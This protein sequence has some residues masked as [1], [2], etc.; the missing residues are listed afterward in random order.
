[1]NYHAIQFDGTQAQYTA[2]FC[3]LP[4]TLYSKRELMQDAETERQLIAGTHILS[5]YFQ[6]YPFLA[7]D[8][9]AQAA[10][11]CILTLYPDRTGAYIG[12]F[13]SIPD[14]DA[15][16]CVLCAA[17]QLAAEHGYRTAV[18][19]V[20]CAFWIRYRLKTDHFGEPYSGEPYNKAYYESFF[21]KA[22]YTV[23]G[24]YL[25]NRFRRIPD[26]HRSQ[27][28]EKRLAA[29]RR[30]GY[31][32]VSPDA[33]S[34]PRAL[35]EIYGMLIELYS[36]FQTFVRITEEEFVSLYTPLRHVADYSMVKIAYYHQKPVGF[37]VSIP[38]CG[39]ALSGTVNPGKLL[40]ILK[41]KLCGRDY[42]MLYM[43]ADPAHPGLGT[44]LAETIK[45]TLAEKGARSVGALIHKGKVSAG[46][47]RDLVEDQYTYKLYEKEL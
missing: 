3:A 47:F 10:A 12:F 43:G 23:S 33:A 34:F 31:E 16:E 24:E 7:L 46:Y 26:G 30:M 42:V 9:N 20:D 29:F 6:V 41:A 38:N 36:D 8:E 27:K 21:L 37:F 17:E 2:A 28:A 14:A 45:Q 11:R 22:G 19:P 13:E 15:A 35:H 25:S 4:G 32:I 39:N 1:M 5:R 18:G 44:A 40:R